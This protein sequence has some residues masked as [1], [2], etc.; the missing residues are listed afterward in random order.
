MPICWTRQQRP[1]TVTHR[2]HDGNNNESSHTHLH[3]QQQAVWQRPRTHH[4]TIGDNKAHRSS[5]D[6]TNGIGR[7]NDQA[8]GANVEHQNIIV[9]ALLSLQ[10]HHGRYGRGLHLPSATQT[11]RCSVGH[12]PMAIYTFTYWCRPKQTP[13][14]RV[15]DVTG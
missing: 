3:H 11:S 13:K 4:V 5:K 15:A 6:W 2:A 9:I 10:L 12:T 7:V 14:S 1:R 8:G